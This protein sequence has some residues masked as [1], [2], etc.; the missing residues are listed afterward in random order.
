MIREKNVFEYIAACLKPSYYIIK[1]YIRGTNE[2]T[3]PM[4]LAF[5][6]VGSFKSLIISLKRDLFLDRMVLNI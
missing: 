3:T 4:Q 6:S 1:S 2:G 5:F